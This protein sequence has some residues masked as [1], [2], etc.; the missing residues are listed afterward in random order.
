MLP[1]LPML[2]RMRPSGVSL[3]ISPGLAGSSAA[4]GSLSGSASFSFAPPLATTRSNSACSLFSRCM[5]IL[6]RSASSVCSISGIWSV[7]AP[8]GSLATM[9]KKVLFSQDGP[10]TWY[11]LTLYAATI[12]LISGVK[13]QSTRA[14]LMCMP[15]WAWP[16]MICIG[17]GGA[18][19]L[20]ETTSKAIGGGAV[21]PG[22]A[23]AAIGAAS[24]RQAAV[25]NHEWVRILLRSPLGGEFLPVFGAV[26]RARSGE[27]LALERNLPGEAHGLLPLLRG[28]ESQAVA[29]QLAIFDLLNLGLLPARESH[30]AG[31]CAG[32]GLQV[33]RERRG[34]RRRGLLAGGELGGP[35][36]VEPRRGGGQGTCENCQRESHHLDSD[37]PALPRN[38]IGQA[39]RLPDRRE[40]KLEPVPYFLAGGGAAAGAAALAAAAT[41][42]AWS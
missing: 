29:L 18:D 16:E 30:R 11:D 36:A 40:S 7:L 4:A 2:M 8:S 20:M 3:V 23:V 31:D 42:C 41:G 6:K 14:A 27:L 1:S 17:L 13:P 15:T 25:R 22:A 9:S 38:G 37:T 21:W 32:G 10:V 33:E 19:G 39:H 24:A 28:G 34:R 5:V 12:R 26:S 35:M